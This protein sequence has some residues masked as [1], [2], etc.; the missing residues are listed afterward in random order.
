MEKSY[1][2]QQKCGHTNLFYRKIYFEVCEPF[3]QKLA[4]CA[5]VALPLWIKVSRFIQIAFLF[6]NENVLLW[7][8]V[9]NTDQF[10][11]KVRIFWEGHKIWQNLYFT[12]VYS[13]YSQKLSEDFGLFRIYKLYRQK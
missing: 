12:F 4:E 7:G 13:T 10:K 9:V 11:D 8:D 6:D 3:R 1:K 2:M 5:A